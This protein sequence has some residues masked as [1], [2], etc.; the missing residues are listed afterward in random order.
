MF[1]NKCL[2]V[3]NFALIIFSII[4]FRSVFKEIYISNNSFRL[5]V[6]ANSNEQEDI[7]NKNNIAMK[8]EN[9]ISKITSNCKNKSEIIST[10]EKNIDNIKSIDSNI[11]SIK[12]GKISYS[13]RE[14]KLNSQPAGSYDSINVIIGKGEGKNF[15][16]L[17]SPL[18]ESNTSKNDNIYSFNPLLIDTQT[19]K[20]E[21]YILKLLAH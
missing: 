11:S 16:T 18:E 12:L 3:F 6:T 10:L 9:Y 20:Y 13:E 4:L 7:L 14:S 2:T 19:T 5:H 21:S 17:I 1:K 8:I 15:W